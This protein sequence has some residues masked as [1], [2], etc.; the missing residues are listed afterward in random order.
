MIRD[1]DT[2]LLEAE[3]RRFQNSK[4]ALKNMGEPTIDHMGSIPLPD[5]SSSEKSIS[6]D[7]K[8]EFVRWAGFSGVLDHYISGLS[9]LPFLP[10]DKQLVCLSLCYRLP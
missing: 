2:P 8:L 6:T 3:L 7:Q 5:S 9:F 10:A 4:H 1:S